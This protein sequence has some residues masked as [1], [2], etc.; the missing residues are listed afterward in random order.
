MGKS[1]SPWRLGPVV[2]TRNAR[3]QWRSPQSQAK[4]DMPKEKVLEIYN[5]TGPM[6]SIAK[7]HKVSYSTVWRIRNQ[8]TY[9]YWTTT[10]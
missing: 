2:R 4:L 8:Q 1:N 7:A 9:T 5:A 10:Q 3:E 6:H